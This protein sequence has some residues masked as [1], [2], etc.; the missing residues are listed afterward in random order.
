MRVLITGHEGFIGS[1]LAFEM[2]KAGHEVSGLSLEDSSGLSK[3]L[4][5]LS[6]LRPEVVF[7]I[8]ANSDT[9]QTNLQLMMTQNVLAT[10]SLVDYCRLSETKLIFSSSAS[11]Y[12]D[13]NGVPLNLYAWTKLIGENYVLASGGVALRYFN[14][15][16]PGENHKGRMASFALQALV[17]NRDEIPVLLFPMTP[18]RDFVYI[19]DVVVANFRAMEAYSECSGRFF[20]VGTGSARSF[21]EVLSLLQIEWDYL[22]KSAIPQGYQFFTEAAPERFVPGWEPSFSLERGLS[23]YRNHF[24]LPA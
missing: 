16:G 14:V 10:Q 17:R 11:V 20:D 23:A 24:E 13:G 18:R 12:G 8:G 6:K 15:Y 1:A 2:R 22:P 9:L 19:Q 21:E 3:Y 7:H 5:Q 4:D